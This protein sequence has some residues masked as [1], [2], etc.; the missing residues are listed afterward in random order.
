MG[1]LHL[2]IE[3][4][5]AALAKH[6]DSVAPRITEAPMP[7]MNGGWPVV[8]LN[9][10]RITS[11]PSICR[12][13]VCNVGGMKEVRKIAQESGKNIIVARRQVGVIAF[14][15]DAD[16]RAT[17]SPYNIKEWDLHSIELN[18]SPSSRW[19]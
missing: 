4:L 11:F 6:L 18:V 17:F 14:G 8:R 13:L 10:L 19:K 7:P 5:P 12:R 9:A 3:D 1:D 2:M 16:V 15:S